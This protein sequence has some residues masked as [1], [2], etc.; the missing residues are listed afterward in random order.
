M[1]DGVVQF[2]LFD[3]EDDPLDHAFWQF[4]FENPHVYDLL[5]RFALEAKASGRR[6]FGIALIYERMRWYVL[7]E[8]ND[9]AGFKLNNNFRS[10][11]ARLLM[12]R[13]AELAEFF[14]I[15][16]LKTGSLL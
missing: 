16:E 6:R 2:G 8:T 7:I 3:F 5:V 4:H 15:R 14:E 12:W 13:E 10:R 9:P 11:Y 1:T